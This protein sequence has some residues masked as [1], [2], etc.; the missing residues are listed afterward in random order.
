MDFRRRLVRSAKVSARR[1][2]VVILDRMKLEAVGL[3]ALISM[4]ALSP[5]WAQRTPVP[6]ATAI[7]PTRPMATAT[8]A[9]EPPTI[10]GA[11]D[12]DVWREAIALTDFVQAEP[13]EGQPAS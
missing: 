3:S 6:N 11:L 2:A 1:E 8:R 4:F 5:A 10:D 9:L 13:L 12:E 7:T